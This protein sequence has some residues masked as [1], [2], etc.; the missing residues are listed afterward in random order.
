MPIVLIHLT[1]GGFQEIKHFKDLIPLFKS[2]RVFPTII[3]TKF[4]HLINDIRARIK[5]DEED[6]EDEEKK[7]TPA[8]R[9]AKVNERIGE[10]ISDYMNRVL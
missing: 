5:A 8:L 1:A 3:F 9:E 6:E 2:I 4:D 7:L 10:V